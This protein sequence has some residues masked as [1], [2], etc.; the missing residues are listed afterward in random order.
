[1]FF[2]SAEISKKL[3]ASVLFLYIAMKN[4]CA[5]FAEMIFVC[6]CLAIS[7]GRLSR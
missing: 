2:Y 5:G 6:F 4:S 3:T 1:M 7:P